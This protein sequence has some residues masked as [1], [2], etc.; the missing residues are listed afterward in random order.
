FPE[1]VSISRQF[2][3]RGFDFITITLD[4]PE[5]EAEAMAFLKR[6]GAGPTDRALKRISS[7]NRNTNHY[8]YTGASQDVLADVLDPEWPGP[9]PHTVLVA[10]GGE[11][12]WRHNGIIDGKEAR[13][14]IAEALTRYWELPED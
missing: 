5:K 9:I 13:S 3:M 12:I 10:P 2:D 7:D 8:L 6:Y 4:A 1:L 14:Q 11:I